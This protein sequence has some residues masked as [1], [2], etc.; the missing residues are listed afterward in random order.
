MQKDLRR[1]GT[2]LQVQQRVDGGASFR[3]AIAEFLD[4]FYLDEI[5]ASRRD[6]LAE[7]PA[8]SGDAVRDAYMGAVGEHLSSRWMLGEAPSWV[9][10]TERFLSKPVFIGPERFKAFLLAESP[11]AFR[12]RFLFTEAEPLRRARM[13]RDLKWWSY[14]TLRNGSLPTKEDLLEAIALSRI[15]PAKAEGIM[16]KWPTG[17]RMELVLG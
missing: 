8:L 14:E 17:E 15:S 3:D 10:E 7:R 5:L 2:L 12:R 1:P 13:P 11:S 4:E 9:H 6:R 16:A